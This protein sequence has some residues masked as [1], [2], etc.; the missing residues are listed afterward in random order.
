MCIG[1]P[2]RVIESDGFTALCEG[3]GERR[4]VNVMLL[5]EAAPGGW[6]LIH[7]GNAVR[8]LDEEEASQINDALDALTAALNGEQIDQYFTDLIRH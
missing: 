1:L 6:V 7:L 3:R 4:R 8:L 5:D 2:M